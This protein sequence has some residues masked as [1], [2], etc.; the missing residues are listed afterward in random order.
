MKLLKTI[1]K[2]ISMVLNLPYT[3]L[4]AL[5]AL[6]AYRVR[7]VHTSGGCV[8]FVVDKIRVGYESTAGQTIGWLVC[9]EKPYEYNQRLINHEL[10]H[11][12]KQFL[13]YP[14]VFPLMYGAAALVAVAQG[15][16]GYYD[17]YF[18]RE[19]RRLS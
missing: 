8:I 3:L 4:Y 10:V 16:H 2:Q 18:E 1:L 11:A 9:V 14:L 5:F 19:A 7:R 13:R 12:Q 6:A 15:G 17:N